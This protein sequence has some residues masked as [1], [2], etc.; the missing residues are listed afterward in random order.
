MKTKIKIIAILLSFSLFYMSCMSCENEGSENVTESEE[1]QNITPSEVNMLA[2]PI[3]NYKVQNKSVRKVRKATMKSVAASGVMTVLI[4]APYTVQ[5]HANE[6]AAREALDS[7]ANKPYV[8][9]KKTVI[10]AYLGKADSIFAYCDLET[11]DKSFAWVARD[12]NGKHLK[13]GG[14]NAYNYNS[15]CPTNCPSKL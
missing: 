8:W 5:I 12:K 11:H 14:A 1:P 4:N 15:I 3:P 7:S 9:I 13:V 6:K 2:R 10:E